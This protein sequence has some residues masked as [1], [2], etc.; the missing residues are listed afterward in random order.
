MFHKDRKNTSSIS[1]SV[2]DLHKI[3]TATVFLADDKRQALMKKIADLSALDAQRYDSLCTKLI[4]NLVDYCQSLPETLNSYY[5][6]AGGLIDYALNRTEAALSLFQEFIVP[7]ENGRLSEEQ[8]LWQYALLSAAL[9]QGIG[10]LFVD[11]K[12][13]VFDSKGH[14]LTD[15][16]PLLAAMNTAGS[17]F[18]YEFKKEPEVTFR[19]RINLLL[20][21]SIVPDSGFSWIAS[22]EEVLKVWLAL[23]NEDERSA[24]TLGAILIR[25]DALAIQRYLTELMLR[26]AANQTPGRYG[27]IGTFSG[28]TPE[29]LLEKEQ[30]VGFD[31]IQWTITSLD[32]GRIMVNKAPL[33]IVPGGMLMCQEMFQ[34]FVRE[35]PEYKNWQAV[36]KGLSALGLLAKDASGSI[37]SRFEHKE[38][39]ETQ[40]YE[41]VVLSKLAIILPSEVPVH[42]PNGGMESIAA[43][44]LLHKTQY[45]SPLTQQQNPI[46]LLPIQKLST[47]GIWAQTD[48]RSPHINPGA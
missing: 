43:M 16:N 22:N 6:Q 10:K 39:T 41:G 42:S 48:T 12:V 9:L 8:T 36:Q 37:A 44:E 14:A 26:Y 29:N 1:K 31:F 15:W 30:L 35:H 11:F 4:I 2:K 46:G 38:G 34:L 7:N 3:S 32:S 25:A 20:A 28:G 47:T 23:L 13:S 19:R 5:S 45:N 17:Y 21:K 33:F 24:G 27:Q 40:M 18:S